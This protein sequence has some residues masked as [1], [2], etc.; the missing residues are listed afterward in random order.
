MDLRRTVVSNEWTVC[1]GR[2]RCF[3]KESVGRKEY[4][5]MMEDLVGIRERILKGRVP[6]SKW[7][8]SL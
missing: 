8:D 4:W 7:I 2:W 1:K 5:V 3:N 6:E